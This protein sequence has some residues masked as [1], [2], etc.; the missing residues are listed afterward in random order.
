MSDE[1]GGSAHGNFLRADGLWQDQELSASQE[2]SRMQDRS[3]EALALL[4]RRERYVIEQ[5]VMS[6]DRPTLQ[7]LGDHFGISGERA[8]QLE[9]RAKKKLRRDLQPLATGV[10]ALSIKRDASSARSRRP[11]RSAYR[12][13]PSL[14]RGSG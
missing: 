6:D 11:R 13:H 10:V 3:L 9:L 1:G 8:R 2:K 4:D 5:R 7:A 12:P 14:E